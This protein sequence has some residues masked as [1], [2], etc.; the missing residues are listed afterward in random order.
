MCLY[1]RGVRCRG[2]Y[3]G[4]V[5][6]GV[7][8]LSRAV[9]LHRLCG[10]SR[11]AGTQGERRTERKRGMQRSRSRPDGSSLKVYYRSTLTC[12]LA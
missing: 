5:Q 6:M 1:K 4:G 12:R 8:G 11:L 3:M 7:V 9:V 2:Y 10:R